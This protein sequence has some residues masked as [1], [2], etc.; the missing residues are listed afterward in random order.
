[1]N[2]ICRLKQ[3]RGTSY[4]SDGLLQLVV[5]QSQR[6][7]AKTAL[8]HNE[9]IRASRKK[10]MKYLLINS[11]QHQQQQHQLNVFISFNGLSSSAWDRRHTSGGSVL[12]NKTT[13]ISLGNCF[14]LTNCKSIII[15]FLF[16][17]LFFHFE[18]RSTRSKAFIRAV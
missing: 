18:I 7:F 17:S 3:T 12:S 6:T 15:L 10:C 2:S 16:F 4:N 9:L 11:K 5:K 1:M 13:Q 8:E 14:L